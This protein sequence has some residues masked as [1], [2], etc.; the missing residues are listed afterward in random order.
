MDLSGYSP[1]YL[2]R[3]VTNNV[4][5]GLLKK[6]LLR[7]SFGY[8]RIMLPALM[9]Y[10][11]DMDALWFFVPQDQVHMVYRDPRYSVDMTYEALLA[12]KEYMLYFI[13][14]SGQEGHCKVHRDVLSNLYYAAFPK[15]FEDNVGSQIMLSVDRSCLSNYRVGYPYREINMYSSLIV[16]KNFIKFC[17]RETDIQW[18]PKR[19]LLNANEYTDGDILEPFVN[20]CLSYVSYNVI[21]KDESTNWRERVLPVSKDLLIQDHMTVMRAMA[22]GVSTEVYREWLLQE[23]GALKILNLNVESYEN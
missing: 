2:A 12:D 22:A 21:Y 4:L 15:R 23:Y 8:Y 16:P 18:V 10:V 1:D 17:V 6:D 5:S 7:E 20:V 19:D 9:E 11:T 13:T 3:F 14:M